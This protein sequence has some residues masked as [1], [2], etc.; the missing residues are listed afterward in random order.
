MKNDTNSNKIIKL[1]LIITINKRIGKIKK[2]KEKKKTNLLPPPSKPYYQLHFILFSHRPIIW[3][4]NNL[5]KSQCLFHAPLC[6]LG[7][8]RALEEDDLASNLVLVIMTH[9]IG[10]RTW[11]LSLSLSGE[12]VKDSVDVAS[13]VMGDMTMLPT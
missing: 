1:K 8:G 12:E 7:L 9:L 4:P 3:M 6:F 13:Y 2:M 11:P 5:P 10:W